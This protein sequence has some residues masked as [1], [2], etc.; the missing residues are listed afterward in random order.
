MSRRPV[1]VTISGQEYHIV[2][3]A[4]EE[5]LQRVASYVDETIERVRER[6]GTVDSLE[7]AMLAALN[8][9]RELVAARGAP[10]AAPTPAE[11]RHLIERVEAVAGGSADPRPS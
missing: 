4:D 2:S 5:S 9:A 11:L 7:V 6:T 8:I 1:S 10:D 3:D